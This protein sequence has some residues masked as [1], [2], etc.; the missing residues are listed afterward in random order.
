MKR[1]GQVIKV[2]PEKFQEYT[3]AH[4]DVWPEVL[5]MI[6]QCNIKN[7]SIYH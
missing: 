4:A 2:K 1:L 6:T 5:A 7:Y 3:E